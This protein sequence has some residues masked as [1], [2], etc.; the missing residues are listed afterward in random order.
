MF[1]AHKFDNR[2]TLQQQ[3]GLSHCMK[4]NMRHAVDKY[5]PHVFY[6]GMNAQRDQCPCLSWNLNRTVC[7]HPL[8]RK[9]IDSTLY[10][11]WLGVMERYSSGISI[12][13]IH[14]DELRTCVSKSNGVFTFFD[15]IRCVAMC[16]EHKH[17]N[18]TMIWLV[19]FHFWGTQ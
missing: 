13:C 6:R 10:K 3:L 19:P 4:R 16:H 15:P 9:C 17:A 2:H 1:D 14:L 11:V 8:K 7:L 18:L 5:S 12:S